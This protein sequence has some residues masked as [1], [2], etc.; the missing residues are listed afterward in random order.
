VQLRCQKKDPRESPNSFVFTDE[1]NQDKGLNIESLA[2]LNQRG[3]FQP[4]GDTLRRG[5]AEE[6]ARRERFE[7]EG[8]LP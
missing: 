7:L 4:I 6:E 1:D 5:G 2:A 8:A 3:G